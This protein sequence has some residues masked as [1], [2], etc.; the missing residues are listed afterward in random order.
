MDSFLA[1]PAAGV[2]YTVVFA[3][4]SAL[5]R[6]GLSPAFLAQS[7]SI[8]AVFT[9]ANLLGGARLHPVAFL[10]VL[11]LLSMRI[12]I[13]LD[14]ASLLASRGSLG[15]ARRLHDLALR[16]LP[17]VTERFVVAVNGAVCSLQAGDAASA[18]AALSAALDSPHYRGVGVKHR[19]AAHYNLAVAYGR[20]KRKAEAAVEL[21]RVIDLWP[22]SEYARRAEAL[23]RQG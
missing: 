15:R 12:R 18:A 1:I 6:E 8:T 4:M 7:L 3:A 9:I 20:E 23:L 16:L 13:L 22:V 14:L 10:I 17:S 5:R 21:Q 19:S 11:Y 2:L